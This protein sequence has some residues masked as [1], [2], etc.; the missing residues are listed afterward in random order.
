G[1]AA[2]DGCVEAHVDLAVGEVE[3]LVRNQA[4]A[5]VVGHLGVEFRVCTS[6]EQHQ[7]LGAAGPDAGHAGSPFA[8]SSC[9]SWPLCS[10]CP[11]GSSA[12]RCWAASAAAAVAVPAR[13]CS[14][15]PAMLR[16][17]E[18]ATASSPGSVPAV[19]V[20]PAAT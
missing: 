14:T 20:E 2:P 19:T 7:C 4:D 18:R 11:P 16:C 1:G 6:S 12:A 10:C 17:R 13:R 9:L 5:E 15:Q 3:R 8:R